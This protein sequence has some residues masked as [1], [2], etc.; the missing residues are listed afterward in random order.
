[1]PNGTSPYWLEYAKA[2]RLPFE[3]EH[4]AQWAIK[5]LNLDPVASKALRLAQ[6]NELDEFCHDSY[7]N[8]TIYKEKT[9]KWH[10]YNIANQN[11]QVGH[12]VLLFNSCLKLFPG[13]LKSRW[14]G[15][16]I[17]TKLFPYGAFEIEQ[18]NSLVFKVNGQHL[19]HYYGG[20]IEKNLNI[21]L[22]DSQS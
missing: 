3:V 15:P 5:K 16:F 1:M 4:K 12:K 8:A 7:E 6:L 11:F 22:V 10:D 19:K 21:R 9:K 14:P 20:G 2:S 13:K 17:V 18:G